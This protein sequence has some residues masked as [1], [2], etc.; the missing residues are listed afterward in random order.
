MTN[1]STAR[2][3]YRCCNQ[4]PAM[5][6]HARLRTNPNLVTLHEG[7]VAEVVVIGSTKG[8]SITM[9]SRVVL[10]GQFLND[11]RQRSRC[12]LVL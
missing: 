12:N 6:D 10:D 11:T 4:A 2:A 1:S 5:M 7:A 9:I 8:L 3:G